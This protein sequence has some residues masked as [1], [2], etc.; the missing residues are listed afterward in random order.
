MVLLLF[1]SA[2]DDSKDGDCTASEEIYSRGIYVVNEGTFQAGNASITYY[3][4]QTE[5]LRSRIFQRSDCEP[6]TLG[7][8][9]QSLTFHEGKVFIVVNNSN[10]VEVVDALNFRSQATVTGLALPR[11]LHAVDGGK[12]YISEWGSDGLSG[13]LQILDLS[14]YA[15][16][17]HIE[18]GGKGP[19]KMLQVGD[20]LYVGHTGGFAS[21]S[22]ISVIDMGADTLLTQIATRHNPAEMALDAQG[23]L[24]VLSLGYYD[25][26]TGEGF[27]A[28]LSCYEVP[29]HGLLKQFELPA[30]YPADLHI[31]AAGDRLY[32]LH[33]AA[34]VAQGTE[35]SSLDL[36]TLAND[37]TFYG[38]GF[39]ASAGRLY[40]A[41]AGDFQSNGRVRVY[42]TTG[43]FLTEW[44]AGIAPSEIV[45]GGE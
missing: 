22:L 5:E 26:E 15:I 34:I 11:F 1:N 25:F 6:K 4:P 36:Q 27:P 23:R 21:D 42:D 33:D 37:A 8:V 45:A 13:R 12:A 19:E 39:D 41:D 18:T 44:A 31:N 10:K 16:T 7:D 40:G 20:R 2:C 17:G 9:A 30:S 29:G 32:F 35:S 38:L 3:E 24:W 43:T 28:Y 14:S